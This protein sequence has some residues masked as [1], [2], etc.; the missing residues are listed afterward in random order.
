MAPSVEGD[1][2]ALTDGGGLGRIRVDCIDRT[3]LNLVSQ[4]KFSSGR[5]LMVLPVSQP[6]LDITSVAGREIPLGTGSLVSVSLPPG[7]PEAQ[8]IKVRAK[9][10]SGKVALRVVVTPESGPARSVDF[11]IDMSTQNPIE[12]VIP[13]SIPIG[14]VSRIN[15]W[16]R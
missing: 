16:T 14:P 12:T 2:R 11:E 10:F 4:G 15:V 5:K 8:T 3:R 9:D 13:I 7:A 1:G 6:R